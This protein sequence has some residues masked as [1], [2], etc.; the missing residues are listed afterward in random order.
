MAELPKDCRDRHPSF[1]YIDC[2]WDHEAQLCVKSNTTQT[3][4]RRR[5]K[6]IYLCNSYV[7]MTEDFSPKA[8]V[9]VERLLELL[10]KG[11]VAS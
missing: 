8:L 7:N 10:G 2:M 5:S 3:A 11:G 9:I 6:S 4:Y 1:C